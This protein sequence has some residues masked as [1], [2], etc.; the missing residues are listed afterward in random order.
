M[1]KCNLKIESHLL[2]TLKFSYAYQI[3]RKLKC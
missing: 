1:P 2:T 3:E